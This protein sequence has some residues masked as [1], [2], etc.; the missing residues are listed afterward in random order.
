MLCVDIHSYQTP[1]C[2]AGLI[3]DSGLSGK[4]M[5]KALKPDFLLSGQAVLYLS[6]PDAVT[7]LQGNVGVGGESHDQLSFSM[8]IRAKE[9]RKL[10]E[11]VIA[12]GMKGTTLHHRT[13]PYMWLTQVRYCSFLQV[14]VTSLS[15][16][17]DSH[18]NVLVYT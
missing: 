6:E 13:E 2:E 5:G 4:T 10:K 8:S 3:S 7:S 11:Y 18:N 17:K 12:L 15:S 14:N 9:Q 1:T 16:H